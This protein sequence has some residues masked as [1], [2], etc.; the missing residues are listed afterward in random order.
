MNVMK[1]G[2]ETLQKSTHKRHFKNV[3]LESIALKNVTLKK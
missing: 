3:T 2:V 1:V